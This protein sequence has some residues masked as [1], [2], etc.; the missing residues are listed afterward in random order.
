MNGVPK[1]GPH[2]IRTKILEYVDADG[3]VR[4]S[5]M[6]QSVEAWACD[7]GSPRC[8]IP[9]HRRQDC[10]NGHPSIKS[11]YR[12]GYDDGHAG[13]GVDEDEE[14]EERD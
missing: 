2:V 3:D 7:E 13:Y 4:M 11:C 8:P 1:T 5:S 9:T 6:R 14:K 10:R 12:C